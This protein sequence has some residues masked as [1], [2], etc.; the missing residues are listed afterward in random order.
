MEQFTAEE[1]TR[2][3]G[4]VRNRRAEL[5]LSLAAVAEVGGTSDQTLMAVEK[6]EKLSYRPGS[7]AAVEV[8]LG[9]AK[10]SIREIAEGATLD[11]VQYVDLRTE[12]GERLRQEVLTTDFLTTAAGELTASA[13]AISKSLGDLGAS[14]SH[15][16]A[17]PGLDP[18]YRT[19]LALA[20]EGLI[21]T[22]QDLSKDLRKSL[23]NLNHQMAAVTPSSGAEVDLADHQGE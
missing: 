14:V 13:A 4:A 23:N 12:A 22:I 2:V 7:I 10:G 15:I 1:A 9:L 3:A 5:R 6:G 18:R 17:E 11:E 8:G 19:I 20:V 16:A 21:E